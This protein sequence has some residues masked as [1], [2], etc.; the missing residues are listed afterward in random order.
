[1]ITCPFLFERVKQGEIIK[2]TLRSPCY[3]VI[4]VWPIVLQP[5]TLGQVTLYFLKEDLTVHHF[6]KQ[7]KRHQNRTFP[8]KGHLVS[9][10]VVCILSCW[11]R[12][13]LSFF[14]EWTTNPDLKPWK[15]NMKDVNRDHLLSLTEASDLECLG[16][17]VGLKVNQS[18]GDFTISSWSVHPRKLTWNPRNC[19]FFPW[20]FSGSMLVFQGVTWFCRSLE[21]GKPRR[22]MEPRQTGIFRG[23]DRNEVWAPAGGLER[24]KPVIWLMATRNPANQLRLVVEIPLFTGFYTSQVVHD[25]LNQQYFW[26]ELEGGSIP[27]EVCM[28][29]SW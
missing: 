25:F 26:R 8:W 15:K 22:M 11:K 6:L 1:M 19:W 20:P 9:L 5:L 2:E 7:G 21:R 16:E 12:G 24:G 4:Q 14:L 10:N 13:I 27:R 17:D 3:F 28:F 29:F 18:Y 23:A